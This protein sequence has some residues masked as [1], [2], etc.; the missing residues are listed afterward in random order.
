MVGEKDYSKVKCWNFQRMGQ[1]ADVCLEKKKK[2][3]NQNMTASTEVEDI[4]DRF[5]REFGFIAFE[6]T[7]A[8]SPAT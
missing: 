4:T 2:G 6:S 5:D 3:K 7:S 1:Y 8:G